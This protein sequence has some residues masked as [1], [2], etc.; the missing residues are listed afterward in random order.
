MGEILTGWLGRQVGTTVQSD[1]DARA[2]ARGPPPPGR[3]TRRLATHLAAQRHS[4]LGGW[5]LRCRR[6]PHLLEIAR[7]PPRQLHRDRAAGWPPRGKSRVCGQAGQAEAAPGVKFKP[8]ARAGPRVHPPL[9]RL[10]SPGS[11][12]CPATDREESGVALA[13]PPPPASP[14]RKPACPERTRAERPAHGRP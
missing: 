13:P 10:E 4:K 8:A 7:Q 6:T 1:G 9:P 5:W 11:R 14:T 2:R 12:R 3:D